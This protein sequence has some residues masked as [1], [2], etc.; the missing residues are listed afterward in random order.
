MMNLSNLAAPKG[1]RKNRKRLGRGESSGQ[2]KTAG[3]GNKGQNA[4][5]GAKRKSGFEGGQMPMHRRLP[6]FGFTNIFREDRVHVKLS[7][8][9]GFEDGTTVD[10]EALKEAGLV[11]RK[12]EGRIKV[13]GN[14]ELSKKLTV[15]VNS[16][17]QSA[18]AAIEKA[19]G[20]TEV[21]S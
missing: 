18:K 1:A 10:M 17:S 4:R 12:F 19:G 20:Q 14:G 2:G 7:D 21:V 15:K 11:R 13:L 3:K 8:L 5:A 16:F 6:K 9:N